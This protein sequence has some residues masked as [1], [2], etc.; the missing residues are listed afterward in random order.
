MKPCKQS[1]FNADEVT[2]VRLRMRSVPGN[3]TSDKYSGRDEQAPFAAA[4]AGMI[5]FA[6]KRQSTDFPNT[7]RLGCPPPKTLRALIAS[8][9]LPDRELRFHLRGCSECFSNYR[10]RLAAYKIEMDALV[11]PGWWEV[12]RELLWPKQRWAFA[13]ALS[14]LLL[15]LTGGELMNRSRTTFSEQ[16]QVSSGLS[17]T[18]ETAPT[19]EEDS[20]S[21]KQQPSVAETRR[22]AMQEPGPTSGA[23]KSNRTRVARKA[24]VMKDPAVEHAETVTN[25]K[26]VTFPPPVTPPG[27]LSEPPAPNVV[28]C[29]E[30]GGAVDLKNPTNQPLNFS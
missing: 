16:R 25:A 24:S 27:P 21:S 3:N 5:V 15:F 6:Q 23:P 2:N 19:A 12:F 18:Q 8:G 4:L 30:S 29:K 28:T 13:G 14:L 26:T 11:T 9:K 7:E 17:A 22:D 20:R 10:D 1:H